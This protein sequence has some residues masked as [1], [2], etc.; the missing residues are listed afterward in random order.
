M[1]GHRLTSVDAEDSDDTGDRGV[2]YH[3]ECD[4]PPGWHCRL[5]VAADLIISCGYGPVASYGVSESDD[6]DA[7]GPCC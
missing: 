7:C 4:P 6:D 5:R 3:D 1:L 2:D